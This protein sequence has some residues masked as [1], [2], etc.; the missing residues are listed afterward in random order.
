MIILVSYQKLITQVCA[1]LL[2][3]NSAIRECR[4]LPAEFDYGQQ[5]GMC[6]YYLL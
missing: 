4:N 6:I 1:M 2:K 3:Y 5:V